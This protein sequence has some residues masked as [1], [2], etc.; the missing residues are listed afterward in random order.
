MHI[1]EQVQLNIEL[2]QAQISHLLV[3]TAKLS[4][5][6]RWYELVTFAAVS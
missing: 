4:T 5:E 6:S 3:Q 1:E 2:I